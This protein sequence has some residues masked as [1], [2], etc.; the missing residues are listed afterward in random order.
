M[1]S[2]CRAL[3]MQVLAP[4]KRW[5]EASDNSHY[6]C[7]SRAPLKVFS[8]LNC[9][10]SHIWLRETSAQKTVAFVLSESGMK[11][12]FGQRNWRIIWA[13]DNSKPHFVCLNNKKKK[14]SCGLFMPMGLL[15]NRTLPLV[16]WRGRVW[17]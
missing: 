13:Q 1:L 2:T 17:A 11:S 4:K 12:G 15:V 3:L 5:F 7:F 6:C 9:G 10:F 8:L 14:S 16:G